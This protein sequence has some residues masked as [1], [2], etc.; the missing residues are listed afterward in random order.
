LERAISETTDETKVKTLIMDDRIIITTDL[1]SRLKG[2][3]DANCGQTTEN[4]YNEGEKS[5]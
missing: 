4:A 1:T 3:G 5:R 2:H